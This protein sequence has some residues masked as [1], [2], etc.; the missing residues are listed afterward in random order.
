MVF[1]AYLTLVGWSVATVY[2]A[3]MVSQS[4]LWLA[5]GAGA[6]TAMFAGFWAYGRKHRVDML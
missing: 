5:V 2:H 1:V 3:V 6:L 4:V